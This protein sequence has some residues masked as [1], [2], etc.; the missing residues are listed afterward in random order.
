MAGDARLAGDRQQLHILILIVMADP[1]AGTGS[2]T[3]CTTPTASP[4]SRPKRKKWMETD[5]DGNS[6]QRFESPEAYMKRLHDWEVRRLAKK[7]RK[8]SV[9]PCPAC[10][11]LNANRSK[12]CKG[13]VEAIPLSTKRSAIRDMERRRNKIR[14]LTRGATNSDCILCKC[15]LMGRRLG[16]CNCDVD[17]SKEEI[18]KQV[19]KL[20]H[21]VR[22]AR[23]IHTQNGVSVP[24]FDIKSVMNSV[25]KTIG[26]VR[27][28]KRSSNIVSGCGRAAHLD[29]LKEWA[30][31]RPSEYGVLVPKCPYCNVTCSRKSG[32]YYTDIVI[33]YAYNQRVVE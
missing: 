7:K 8:P 10:L 5:A 14:R 30:T 31:R 16:I 23:K 32:K 1:S 21:T 17:R 3:G 11:H 25:A 6:V 18:I 2:S 15:P 4:D 9:K 24:S 27:E 22:E 13:C 26:M 33:D 29:C 12:T 19:E 20:H 28:Q